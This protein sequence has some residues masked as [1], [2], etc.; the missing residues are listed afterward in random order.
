MTTHRQIRGLLVCLLLT[1]FVG[2]TRAEV[3]LAHDPAWAGYWIWGPAKNT[4]AIEID[5]SAW[6]RAHPGGWGKPLVRRI[7]GNAVSVGLRNVYW[8]MTDA[9]GRLLYP[10]GDSANVR[11]WGNWGVDFGKTDMPAVAVETAKELHQNITLVASKTLHEEIRKRYPAVKIILPESVPQNA[12]SGVE[13]T[14]ENLGALG[15]YQNPHAQYFRKTFDVTTPVQSAELCI[16]AM[17]PYRVYLD[18]KLIGSD[19]T[20]QDGETYDVTKRLVVG[21]HVLAVEVKGLKKPS[22]PAGL[23]VNLRWTDHQNNTRLVVTDPTWRRT[24]S[25]NK[26]Q[27]GWSQPE[28]DD[29]VW[30]SSVVVGVEGTGERFLRL[31]APWGNPRPLL[32]SPTCDDML[33][34]DVRVRAEKDP[35]HAKALMDRG[36]HD[37]HSRRWS[38]RGLPAT[39]DMELPRDEL[40]G[41]IRLYSGWLRYTYAPSGPGEVK[42]FRLLAMVAGTWTDV[43]KEQVTPPYRREYPLSTYYFETFFQP[44]KSNRFRLILLESHDAGKRFSNLGKEPLPAEERWCN[45][46]EIELLRTETP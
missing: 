32:S 38:C 40:V 4:P 8:D 5:L 39:I 46:R 36:I 27:P 14:R 30:K 43:C 12:L 13:I 21:K 41:G 45:L 35:K 44:V 9:E 17:Q 29:N 26:N 28:F 31:G 2:P 15:K 33:I 34:T 6:L 16:T 37:T 1:G 22:W 3:Y 23:I 20:W 42:R 24:E 11:R 7:L 25:L 10:A 18:G 19:A